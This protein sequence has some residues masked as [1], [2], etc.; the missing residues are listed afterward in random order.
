[1]KAPDFAYARPDDLGEALA[2]LAHDGAEPLA[3]G[4]S[5]LPMMHFRVAAPETLVDLGGLTSLRGVEDDGEQIVIGAMTRHADLE[6]WDGLRE[7]LPLMAM[8][9]PHVAHPAIRSRGTLGGSLALADP[10]AEAPAVMTVLGADIVLACAHGERRVP[11]ADFFEGFYA[12]ARRED[13]IVVRVEVP[14]RAR[15]FG[16]HELARRHGDYA[17]AG[18]ALSVEGA[19]GE[20]IRGL[21]AAFFGVADAPMRLPALE[22]AFEDREPD[23]PVAWEAARAALEDAPVLGD[24]KAGVPMR[25]HLAAVVLRRAMEG[26]A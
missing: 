7:R 21:R 13:E 15:R 12:T 20:P 22:A 17:L 24:A 3:G 6:R 16:F 18:V 8:A 25:R 19:A 10:A 1:M 23:D 26:M 5:L 9:L 14:A 11:A 2:L 4:Q